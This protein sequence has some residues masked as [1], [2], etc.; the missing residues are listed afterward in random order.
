[1]AP[2]SPSP[3]K[4]AGTPAPANDER[5]DHHDVT[6]LLSLLDSLP[7]CV[8]CKDRE[9][10]VT[11]VNQPVADLANKSIE[12]HIGKTDFDLCPPK[13]A[14]KYTRDDRRVMETG[15]LFT[16]IEKNESDGQVRHFEVRKS[17]T[18]DEH[19]NICGLQAVFWEVTKQKAVEAALDN[20]RFLLR[21]LLN[22]VPDSIYFKDKESRFIR[23][24]SGLA[25][26]FGVESADDLIGK[27]DAD[28]FTEEHAGPARADEQRVMST[29]EPVLAKV[30]KETWEDGRETWCSTTKLPLRDVDGEIVGTFGIT[31]DITDLVR[32]ENE[33]R[34]AKEAADAASVAK[35]DFLANMSHEIRTPMNAIIGMTELLM[36]TELTQTQREYM[37]MVM[38]SGEN[39]LTLINDILDFSK[40]EA[41][42]MELDQS[43][44]NLRESIGDT[45]KSLAIRAHDKGLELAFSVDPGVPRALVGDVTRLRQ[46][47]VNLVG[48]AIKFTA[49]GEVVLDVRTKELRDDS[50][51][52]HFS[53]S[54]TGI[55]ISP[56]KRD[57][58]FESFQ[59]ADTSTTRGYG[60]TGLG[61]A[62][63]TRFVEL[64][65]GSIWVESEEG[66]GSCFHFTARCQVDK[67]DGKQPEK[68]PAAVIDA[69]VLV[70]DD[71]STNRQILDQML[72]S[73]GM[74]PTL[75]SGARAGL[76]Q[77][78][79]AL[80]AGTPFKLVVSDVNMPEA[81]G[82]E[83]VEWMRADPKLADTPV[84]MLSSSG[85][86]GDGP[87]REKLRIS[88]NLL[89][90]AK[91]SELFEAVSQSLGVTGAEGEEA[92]SAAGEGPGLRPLRILL[93]EDN[94][95]NQQLALGLL[96]PR[97][98]HVTVAANGKE[99]VAAASSQDF[100]LILMDVQM[101]VMDG[102]AATRM[103]REAERE[104][105]RKV[106]IL[107]MTARAMIG[108]R[109][110]CLEA[111][112]DDYIAKPIRVATVLEKLADVMGAQ[113]AREEAPAPA[114]PTTARRPTPT[115][116]VQVL[117]ADQ[118]NWAPAL[119]T[120]DGDRS[121]LRS[122]LQICLEDSPQKL[123]QI[124]VAIDTGDAE[125]LQG[126]AHALH[127]SLLFLGEV[128]PCR[129]AKELETMAAGGDLRGS[130]EIYAELEAAVASLTAFLESYLEEN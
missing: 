70:V 33:L 74:N 130:E 28:F 95:I 129:P 97:G 107:A 99:A 42:K 54:D 13:L 89:K 60:G 49:K 83:F 123:A 11:F 21:S 115:R 3:P 98:H 126:A 29:G 63:S 18:R 125:G 37:S 86:P 105:T 66:K 90:P 103:I 52:L 92:G 40:I 122:L 46:I 120:V 12:E 38:Q 56:D 19:G 101:P 36:D 25:E 128:P 50:A 87:R 32:I 88:R 112:M 117:E 9:G 41:G 76:Q 78:E 109:E 61:L 39:L 104:G 1:M 113:P 65:D 43:V 14:E 64:M 58:I 116:K 68:S 82:F 111:G 23:T 26:K 10:K 48:N 108:D 62:I 77:L 34:E 44:F 121:L 118:F 110:R 84:I 91:Q 119:R 20:E 2:D 114:R 57:K 47:V 45:M 7:V 16:G 100:D 6:D 71:N 80:E 30:E 51:L 27:S 24:S 17:P 22:N 81:D 15:E 55:G 53:V 67:R 31:R 69:P 35:S 8:V 59:Q 106:P 5:A 93:A 75:V 72:G 96:E 73:W 127:G 124:Q 94:T 4:A 79:E 102:F 85:R